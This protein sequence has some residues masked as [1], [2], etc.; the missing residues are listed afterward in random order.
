MFIFTLFYASLILAVVL[1][2]ARDVPILHLV[3][4]P[5]SENALVNGLPWLVLLVLFALGLGT[6]DGTVVPRLLL[7]TWFGALAYFWWN[8]AWNLRA[9]Q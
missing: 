9:G 3:V 5:E 6:I 7:A 1:A 2:A 4:P 8:V